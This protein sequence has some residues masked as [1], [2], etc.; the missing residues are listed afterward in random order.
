[1]YEKIAGYVTNN[2]SFSINRNSYEKALKSAFAENNI[3][4]EGTHALR[5]TYAQNQFVEKINSG[6]ES[7]EALRQVSELMGHHR[8]DITLVYIK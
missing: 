8:P 3:K 4:Y 6:I 2:G 7:R 5:Y 1:M